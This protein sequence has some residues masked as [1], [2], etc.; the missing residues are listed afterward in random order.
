[1]KRRESKPTPLTQDLPAAG[2][3]GIP[4]PAPCQQPQSQSSVGD[5]PLGTFQLAELHR[6]GAQDA[7]TSPAVRK[8]ADQAGRLLRAVDRDRDRYADEASL[9]VRRRDRPRA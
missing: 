4:Q 7:V 2:Y 1:M 6:L 3:R 9:I 5:E 8:D